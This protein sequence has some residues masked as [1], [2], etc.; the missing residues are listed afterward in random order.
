MFKTIGS[1]LNPSPTTVLE[2]SR[3]TCENF[4]Q[5]FNNKVAIIRAN[6][7]LP[8][9]HL[10]IKTQCPN[11]F[12]QFKPVSLSFLTK[13]VNT[14]KPSSSPVDT[15]PPRFFKEVWVTIGPYVREIINSSLS[16]G[17]VPSFCKKAVVEPLIKKTGLDPTILS[18]YRPISKIPFL[19]K[20]LEKI[21]LAELQPFLDANCTFDTFQSGYRTFHSTE[22]AL[23]KV[24][25]DLFLMTDTGDSAILVLL[26]LTAA[27][28]T[29]DH[30]ILL[31]RL[32]DCVG[33]RGTAL[34]WFR[35]YLSGRCFTVRLGDSTSS[36][37]PLNCGV[38]QGSIL[39][40]ILF[41]L[42]LLPLSVIFKR[43]GISYHFY[44]DD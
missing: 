43:H 3:E 44:A 20:I 6:I 38:P 16:S 5:F 30:T 35:S 33:V 10:P 19:S 26:D 15:V 24:F 32:E 9:F 18:N 21:V 11:I 13:I 17:L 1:V 23:L 37:A 29:V 25:N 14:L 41:A 34:E 31:S 39:G 42:Y 7:S 8:L 40:P 4:L 36:T 2:A 28:D 12:N 27:F 22:S